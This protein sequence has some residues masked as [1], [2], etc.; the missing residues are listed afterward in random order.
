MSVPIRAV[1]KK[2]LRLI[3]DA[4][5]NHDIGAE[6][7]DMAY[8]YAG[9]APLSVRL[10]QAMVAQPPTLEETMQL[11][12]GPYFSHFQRV[13]AEG[14]SASSA[15]AAE[16][17]ASAGHAVNVAEVP[18]TP[19]TLVFFLGGCTYA[20]IAALRWLGRNGTPRRDYIVATTHIC[21]GDTLIESL[22]ATC[23]NH[24]EHGDVFDHPRE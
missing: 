16:T 13:A 17:G 9:Y 4:L 24:L 6:P 10:L 8:V 7:P 2:S 3:V 11:L 21:S 22:V 14:G 5:P 1:L 19:V 20:E 15:A 18:A 12:P 23:D